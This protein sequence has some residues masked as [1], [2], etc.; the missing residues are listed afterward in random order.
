LQVLLILQVAFPQ[1]FKVRAAEVH[2]AR[3]EKPYDVVLRN[4]RILDG[5]GNPR[6]FGD[7]G[8]RGAGL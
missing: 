4:G 7:L 2:T 3:E 6:Y 8:I 1:A 5:T